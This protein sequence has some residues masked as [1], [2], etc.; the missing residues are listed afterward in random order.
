MDHPCEQIIQSGLFIK[1]FL[2]E[3]LKFFF[4]KALLIATISGCAS[5]STQ[6]TSPLSAP[7]PK[8]SLGT[9]LWQ[10]AA[11]PAP[12]HIDTKKVHLLN[13]RVENLP[14]SHLPEAISIETKLGYETDECGERP[15]T[16]FGKNL[17][18]NELLISIGQQ[19][20]AVVLENSNHIRLLYN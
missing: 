8:I 13:F 20:G 15:V 10:R 18:L 16:V 9:E 5:T 6:R 14:A 2:P 19:T 11:N 4:F 7:E 12:E 1:T 3:L 17:S